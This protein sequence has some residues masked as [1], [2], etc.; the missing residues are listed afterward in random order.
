[1]GQFAESMIDGS[2]CEQCGEYLGDAVGYARSCAACGGDG[3]SESSK[4][5]RAANRENSN[6]LL[7]DRGYQFEEKNG[8]AHLIVQTERGVV[9]FWPGTGKFAFRKGGYEGRGVFNLMQHAAPARAVID[10]PL[11]IKWM[12]H[13]S[14]FTIEKY[15][16]AG[17]VITGMPSEDQ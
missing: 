4:A 10:V 17:F 16:A 13:M 6:C 9:D 11:E 1:M 8:A 3:D 5:R 2:S 14:R 12:P 7:R 15:L